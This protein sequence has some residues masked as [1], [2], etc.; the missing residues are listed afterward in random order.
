MAD[1]AH[2]LARVTHVNAALWGDFDNDGLN[3]VY[4]VRRGPNQMWHQTENAVWQDV[5][6]TTQTSGGPFNTVDGGFFDADHDGDLDLFLVN[7]DGPDELLNNNLD[8]TFRPIAT[9]RGIAGTSKRSRTIVPVDIDSDR[10][11]DILVIH[12]EPPHDIYLNDRLWSYRVAEGWNTFRSTPA[13]TVISG[14][15]DADGLPELYS[16]TP[17]GEVQRWRMS[18]GDDA[19]PQRLG[20]VDL[21]RSDWAQLAVADVNGDGA[22]ELL[23]VAAGEWRV[24]AQD[25]P[26]YQA[27]IPSGGKLTGAIP[28][29]QDP[30]SGYAIVAVDET[31]GLFR[32][33]PGPGRYPLLSLSFT[34]KEDSGQSMR[35]NASGIGTQLAIRT[36]SRWTTAHLF[37]NHSGPGQSLQPLGVG[38]GGARQADFVAIDWSDGVFSKRVGTRGRSETR[39]CRNPATTFQLSRTVRVGRRK[40][41]I[42]K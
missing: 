19:Q 35:S 40:I 31:N 32:W 22:M 10:D 18:E 42:C 34:G 9:E 3:D 39:D 17:E 11:V 23:V 15:L 5:T 26:A 38:L 33:S 13:L 24:F 16:V 7:S 27:S 1:T 41:H 28:V 29:L 20:Q 4:L 37:R 21:Q 36:G 2:P 12:D 8:G 30:A 6:A 14:D 25:K